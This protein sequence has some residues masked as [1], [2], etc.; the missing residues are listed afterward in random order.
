VL[1]TIQKGKKKVRSWLSWA[2]VGLV[3]AVVEW[4]DAMLLLHVNLIMNHYTPSFKTLQ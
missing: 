4:Y 1:K 2:A 3:A